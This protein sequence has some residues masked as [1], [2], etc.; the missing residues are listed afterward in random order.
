M[1]KKLNEFSRRLTQDPSQ[2][3]A[4]AMLYGAG[5]T[6][7]DMAKPQV[8]IAS[9]WWE[10]NTCNMHLLDLSQAVK[11]GVQEAG[12][13]GLRFNTIG[14]SDGMANGTPGMRYSLVSR[15]LIADSIESVMQ[16][17]HYDAC[18]TL[19]GCDKNMPGSV[20]AMLRVNR[21]GLVIYGGTIRE[22]TC[23]DGRKVD[24]A[25]AF[26]SYGELVAGKK[27]M[28]QLRDVI[29]SACPG[30]GACGGMYTANTMAS[31]LEAMG[32]ALP[33]SASTPA[34]DPRKREECRR[35]GRAIRLL[36]ERGI[37]PRDVVT[38]ESLENAMV[39]G[40]ALGGSTNL[41]LHLLAIARTA[42]VKLDVDDFQRVSDRVPMLG[43]FK[44]SGRHLMA[45][46]DAVG[47]LP[48][49]MRTLLDAGYLHGDCL[50]VTGETVAEN[51]RAVA[52]LDDR[53]EVVRPF[54][55][56]VK[57][58]GH[59][60]VLRG[61]LAPESAIAKLTGKEGTRFSGPAHVFDGE[62]AALEA[63]RRGDIVK[64][65]VIVIRYEGPKGAP[66]MPEMLTLTAALVGAGMGRDVAL[67]TDGRFS[68]ASH[69]FVIGHVSPEAQAG[70][71]IA[72]VRDGDRI[73]IDGEA[74][75][76]EVDLSAAELEAR[77]RTWSPRAESDRGTLAKYARLVSSASQ[78]CM[79]APFDVEE[80]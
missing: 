49:F 40:T 57:K 19:P 68:G 36:L 74:N 43:D 18:V 30:P 37:R 22:G 20:M 9:M 1:S 69:G 11:E 60:R 80:A 8:G 79:T 35:A 54:S 52:P 42:G 24:I 73:T 64:G 10:G 53:Q 15:E 62:Q 21:P 39:V 3:S 25:S 58:T 13:V 27:T 2:V 31:A 63:F 61:N 6:D 5:L 28:E 71:P 17:Q 45:Q 55:R 51:L 14:V 44:P 12:L 76:I 29:R 50:T 32:L 7:E 38:R 23:A 72:L 56:P 41:V 46:L 47:G 77:H 70:G 59:I 4:Q 26:E 66:G 48:A 16:A 67:I 65:E 34:E 33:Y 78:G 75:R